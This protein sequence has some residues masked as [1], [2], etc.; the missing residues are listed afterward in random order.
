VLLGFS[1]PQS[2]DALVPRLRQLGLELEASAEADGVVQPEVVNHTDRRFW[3][4]SSLG[5]A[6]DGELHEAIERAF[7]GQLEWI[8]PVY[9][10]PNVPGRAGLHCPLPNALLVKAS[11]EQIPLRE[12]TDKSRYL[13]GYR[14]YAV[15]EPR[16]NSA[17]ELRSRLLEQGSRRHDTVLFEN[18]PLLVPLSFDPVDTFYP[19]APGYT[20]QWNMVTIRAGGPGTSAWDLTFGRTDITIAVLDS[21]C[22]LSH[23]D[24]RFVPGWQP[25]T[26]GIGM[27]N[28]SLAGFAAGHGTMVAGVA[29]ATTHNLKGVAGVAGGCTVMPLAFTNFTESEA[30]QG[31]SFA[32]SRGVRVINMSFNALVWNPAAVDPAIEEAYDN[33]VVMC[34]SSGNASGALGYPATHRHV[35]ACGATDRTDV[36]RANSNFGFGLSVMA[37]G[38]S[39]PTTTLRGTGD[40]EELGNKDYT[41]GFF[42]TSAAAPHVAGL[43]ALILSENPALTSDQVRRVIEST[44]DKVGGVPYAT[45]LPNGTWDTNMGYGRINALAAVLLARP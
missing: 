17:Y 34:A 1:E 28:P 27:N 18:M 42:G 31:I 23:P 45:S 43:A 29:A 13:P 11:E 25:G 36:R 40:L 3:V 30:S 19:P 35:I 32:V 38:I 2:L 37:P 33:N 6:V 4:R 22:D 10:H 12:D 21:G 15:D 44:A 14:Y 26:L 8:G 16:S 20:G 9:H 7:D 24:L 39:V 41:A 5:E